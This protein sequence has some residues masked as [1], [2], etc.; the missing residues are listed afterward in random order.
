MQHRHGHI[1]W[2][3]MA[4]FL[5]GVVAVGV[6]ATR[7]DAAVLRPT[8][9]SVAASGEPTA[10]EPEQMQVDPAGESEAAA[11][12]PY[13][14]SDEAIS[15]LSATSAPVGANRPGISRSVAQLWPAIV[16]ADPSGHTEQSEPQSDDTVTNT[17]DRPP[18][19]ETTSVAVTESEEGPVELEHTLSHIPDPPDVGASQTRET[20]VVEPEPSDPW[21][22]VRRCESH[23]KYRTNTGNGFY[24]AYQFTRST[25][26]WVAGKIGRRGLIGVRPD[27]AKPADQ[28]RMAQALAFEVAGGGLHHWPVCG[29]LYG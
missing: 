4:L 24:G 13:S 9:V 6:G 7:S 12:V 29:R 28:D 17:A 19:V 18:A 26:D 16:Q 14:Q 20:F 21:L 23:N 27:R 10:G 15:A 11:S 22:A 3:A 5:A 2:I 25:W 1:T 8:L